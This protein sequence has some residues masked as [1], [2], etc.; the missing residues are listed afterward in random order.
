MN[1]VPVVVCYFRY[2]RVRMLTSVLYTSM[3][4]Y[5]VSLLF[6]LLIAAVFCHRTPA[7]RG[8]P[9]TD[10][11]SNFTANLFIV[12]LRTKAL[13]YTTWQYSRL[14][15]DSAY[16]VPRIPLVIDTDMRGATGGCQPAA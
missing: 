8:V 3:Y 4:A 7:T 6:L 15:P 5:R 9:H 2:V 10:S 1:R 12:L 14:C 16:L 11:S 13:E